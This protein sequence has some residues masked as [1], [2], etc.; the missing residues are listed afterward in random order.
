MEDKLY[1]V[2]RKDLSH[3]QRAVQAGHGLSEF[4]LKR[5]DLSWSNGTLVL[6][7][8]RNEDELLSVH[9]RLL[10]IGFDHEVFREPDLSNQITSLAGLGS[11]EV[12]RPISLL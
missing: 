8:V 2:V 12:F 5:R 9:K 1:V 4:L 7:G 10:D 3:S 11:N 6:L